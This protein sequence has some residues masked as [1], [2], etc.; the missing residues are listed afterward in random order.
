MPARKPTILQIIPNLETGGAELSTIEVTTALVKAGARAIVLSE[1]GRLARRIADAGGELILFPAASKNPIRMAWNAR[2]IARIVRANGVDLIHARSRAPAW[3]AL[4]VCRRLG[5]P[6]VTTYHGAYAEKS[7]AKRFY[8][9]VMVRSDVVIA[10]SAYTAGLLGARYATPKEKIAVIHRGVDPAVF[11]AN[12]V[13]LDRV[14]AIRSAWQVSPGELVVLHP[15][16]LT[17]WKGQTDV[18]DAAKAVRLREPRVVF[19]FAGDAQGRDA[20]R[21]SLIQKAAAAGLTS[22]VRFVGHVDDMPAAYACAAVTVIASREP[23]AFGRT[24]IEAQAMACPVIATRIG[25][26]PETVSA[27]P[28]CAAEDRTGWL[29]PPADS[30]ALRNAIVEALSLTTSERQQ[31]GR[32]ARDH[33][34]RSFTIAAMQTAT[35]SV[36]D[37]LLGTALAQTFAA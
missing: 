20:Y 18:I 7:R 10:N 32:R 6:F 8:N 4:V 25:A 27:P 15:A 12:A 13:S 26:P 23:E 17:P 19:V 34:V 14:T 9:S 1:G 35:L 30:E 33:V 21:D 24:S 2:E 37:R 31:M 28:A 11:D 5:L 22:A 36:Y 16:R 3:T 29:I